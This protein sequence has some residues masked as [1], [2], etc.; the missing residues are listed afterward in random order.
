MILS[1]TLQ[2]LQNYTPNPLVMHRNMKAYALRNALLPHGLT[3]TSSWQQFAISLEL[4]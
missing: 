4:L 2:R 3:L 1:G